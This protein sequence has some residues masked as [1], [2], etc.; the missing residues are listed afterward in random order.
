MCSN[1]LIELSEQPTKCETE[2]GTA[3]GS[4]EMLTDH[5]CHVNWLRNLP[6]KPQTFLSVHCHRWRLESGDIS[7]LKEISHGH[8]K[9]ITLLI[10]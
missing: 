8:R 7:R 5:F 3:C 9:N 1:K 10:Y 2:T 4:V 6:M